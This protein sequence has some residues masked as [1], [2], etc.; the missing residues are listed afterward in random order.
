MIIT[1]TLGF[2]IAFTWRE[3]L[4]DISKS[5]VQWLSGIKENNSASFWASMFITFLSIFLIFIT[6][7]W[8]K[9]SEKY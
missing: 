9:E 6:A 4:F 7:R 1:F 2:T 5:F 8:L 3:T